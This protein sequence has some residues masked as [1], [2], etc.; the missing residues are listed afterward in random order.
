MAS[1]FL[2]II[3]SQSAG[4]MSSCAYPMEGTYAEVVAA[5]RHWLRAQWKEKLEPGQCVIG[6]IV[7]S[8]AD[9]ICYVVVYQYGKPGIPE[10]IAFPVKSSGELWAERNPRLAQDLESFNLKF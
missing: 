3:Y 4:L 1:R 9:R 10:E 5:F 2:T 6:W 8:A 7:D